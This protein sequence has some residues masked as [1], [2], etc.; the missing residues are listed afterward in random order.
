MGWSE[1]ASGAKARLDAAMFE[2]APDRSISMDDWARWVPSFARSHTE[3]LKSL[4]IPLLMRIIALSFC[5]R[6]SVPVMTELRAS[7]LQDQLF[8]G[9]LQPGL[10]SMQNIGS[11]LLSCTLEQLVPDDRPLNNRLAVESDGVVLCTTMLVDPSILL[12]KAFAVLVIFGTI[13]HHNQQY[14]DVI[15][16]RDPT[17]STEPSDNIST[18]TPRPFDRKSARAYITDCRNARG[19][20]AAK[21]ADAGLTETSLRMLLTV[22]GQRLCVRSTVAFDIHSDGCHIGYERHLSWYNILNSI[23]TGVHVYQNLVFFADTQL[24]LNPCASGRSPDP[25]EIVNLFHPVLGSREDQLV[26]GLFPNKTA[27]RNVVLSDH[28]W[29]FER[30]YIQHDTDVERCIYIAQRMS[31]DEHWTII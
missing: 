17:P 15:E 14:S 16:L 11:S 9:L 2:I 29:G 8:Q 13:R 18:H 3:L 31:P 4:A 26:L 27:H 1:S 19:R 25:E 7:G 22:K 23:S 5:D 12:R 28:L 30:C 10:D 6:A 21:P 24:S 20:W